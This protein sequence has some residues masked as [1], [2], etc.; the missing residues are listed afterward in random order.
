MI[1]ATS[2]PSSRSRA[3]AATESGLIVSATATSPAAAPSIARYIGVLPSPASA[4]AASSRTSAPIPRSAISLRLPSSTARPSTVAST[5]WPGIA[6]KRSGCR[7]VQSALA[8]RRRRSPA[9]AG[10]RSCARPRRRRR[11]RRASPNP[12]AAITSVRAG[13]PQVIVP[14]LSST[15]VSRR[16]AACSASPPRKRMPCS[17]P[18][19]I[20][21]V[22][23]VGVARPSAH[24]Q[25][26][27]ST[28]TKTITA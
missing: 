14:V 20:P 15:I 4:R 3:I 1:I 22:S 13:L 2:R 7:A 27:I 18:L 11:G 17:A 12:G 16:R 24:G 6:S 26:M 10:A 28:V 5:P 9:R 25:A 23:D 21:T 19:P 8:R